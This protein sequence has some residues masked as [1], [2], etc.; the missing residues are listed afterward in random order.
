[1]N[2]ARGVG[3]LGVL[4]ALRGRGLLADCTSEGVVLKRAGLGNGRPSCYVGFDPTASS[5]H[6]GNLV[7]VRALQVLQTFGVKPIALVGGATGMIGDPSG[8]SDDRNLLDADQLCRNSSGIERALRQVIDFDETGNPENPGAILLNNNSWFS[9]FGV[10]DFYRG[11]GKHFRM[12]TM[13]SR[14]SVKSRLEGP[15]GM[16]FLEFSY[17]LFQAY[18]FLH[19]YEHHNCLMQLGGADQWGNIVSGCELIRKVQPDATVYGVTVPL[20]TTSDGA[21]LGKSAG[22]APIWVDSNLTSHYDFFQY[23]LNTSDADARR[24]IPML[25]LEPGEDSNNP[26][27]LDVLQQHSENPAK[28]QAQKFLAQRVTRWVRG[29]D[30]LVSADQATRALFGGSLRLLSPEDIA[31]AFTTFPKKG[32]HRDD[33]VGASVIDVAVECGAMQSKSECRRLIRSGGFYIN[34]NRVSDAQKQINHEDFVGNGGYLIL[35][36]GK[37]NYFVIEVEG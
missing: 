17:Q 18:D 14:D 13:L 12:G 23:F 20:M 10:L 30:G 26:E 21:K 11:I 29:D 24:L 2:S 3:R 19:L 7:T 35:R 34:N 27:V 37:K 5:L 33:L 25:A 32:L 8:K 15:S 22:N 1:M 6:I 31:S 9:N 16:S 36:S 28:R 4:E